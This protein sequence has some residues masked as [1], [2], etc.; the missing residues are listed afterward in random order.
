MDFDQNCIFCKIIQHEIPSKVVAENDYALAFMDISPASNGHCLVIPKKHFVDLE[1]TN[2]D[3]LMQM[4][5]LVKEVASILS[6]DKQ[7]DPWGFNYLCN[8]G[9]IAGQVVKH[10]HIH[11]IPKYAKNEGFSFSSDNRHLDPV[12][13]VY[14][15]IMQTKQKF[16]KK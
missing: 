8:Q 2:D 5:K 11:I 4:I 6:Y 13:D 14:E 1:H 7:L 16:A 3:Y 10:T 15:G 12:D 9:D